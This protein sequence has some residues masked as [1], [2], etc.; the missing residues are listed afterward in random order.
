MF[1]VTESFVYDWELDGIKK[2]LFKTKEEAQLKV[3]ERF[4]SITKEEYEKDSI[5]NTT[6][7]KNWFTVTLREGVIDVERNEIHY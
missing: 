3:R 4:N 7:R 1:I 6:K 5:E 2:W